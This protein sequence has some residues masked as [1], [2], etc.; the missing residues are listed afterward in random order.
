MTYGPFLLTPVWRF[1]DAY[2]H[3]ISASF[4]GYRVTF[5]EG[6]IGW[7]HTLIPSLP[8]ARA[9]ALHQASAFNGIAPTVL[10]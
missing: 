7:Y 5:A 4:L 8:D 10:P 1:R 3:E 2:R 6:G 9:F